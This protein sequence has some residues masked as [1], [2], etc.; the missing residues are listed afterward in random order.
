MCVG[1]LLEVRNLRVFGESGIGKIGK[2]GNWA[3]GNLTHVTKH[4]ASIVSIGKRADGSPDGKQS[5]SPMD[6]Q[7]HQNALPAFWGLLSNRGFGRLGRGL[8]Y[9]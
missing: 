9:Q 6:T 4:N 5:P 8:H 7:Q 1:C 2:G 3:S